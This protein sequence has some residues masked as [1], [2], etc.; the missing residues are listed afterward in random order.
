M[1]DNLEFRESRIIT[2]DGR[3]LIGESSV[4]KEHVLQ[5]IVNEKR[6]FR[7]VCTASDLKELIVG[8]LYTE[9]LIDSPSEI[10]KYYLC[11]SENEARIFL[12]HEILWEE[13][14]EPEPS[15]CTANRVYASYQGRRELKRLPQHHW[16]KEWIFAL[17]EKFS[18]GTKMHK[19]TKGTHSCFLSQGGKFLF[20]CEDIG[21][22]NAI[23]K[24]VGYALL[25]EIPLSECVLY[26]SGRVPVDMVQKAVSAGIPVLAS[27]AVPTA[28]SIAV[29]SE[30]NLTLICRAYPD[31]F[32]VFE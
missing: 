4:I 9:G 32:E 14:T 24:A 25:N 29:A 3:C 6:A 27:K 11:A 5:I 15:C 1:E 18:E 26:T 30:Y 20:S 7:L 19:E 10:S 21:R 17:A 22:H 28:E 31:Q 2:S 16:E 8:R 23:D 12:D 13:Y